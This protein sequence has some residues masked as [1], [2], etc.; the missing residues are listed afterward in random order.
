MGKRG[1]EIMAVLGMLMTWL[2]YTMLFIFMSGL[3]LTVKNWRK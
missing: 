3:Y 2:V 1:G